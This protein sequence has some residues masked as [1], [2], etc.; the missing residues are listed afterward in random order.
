[1]ARGLLKPAWESNILS[2]MMMA[3]AGLLAGYVLLFRFAAARV[4]RFD[5]AHA[6]RKAAWFAAALL[7]ALSWL[8]NLLRK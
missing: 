4:L 2:P 8:A 6:I 1:M 3:G 7:V 5:N